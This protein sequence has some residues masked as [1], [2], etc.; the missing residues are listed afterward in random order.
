MHFMFFIYIAFCHKVI[1]RVKFISRVIA[2]SIVQRHDG[3]KSAVS[4]NR[5]NPDE[6]R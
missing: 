4:P 2:W 6:R 1:T 5:I 3:Q